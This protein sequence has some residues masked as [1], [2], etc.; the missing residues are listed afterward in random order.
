MVGLAFGGEEAR[1]AV[2]AGE[3]PALRVAQAARLSPARFPRSLRLEQASR[4]LYA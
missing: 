1:Q 4:L 2:G 3:P